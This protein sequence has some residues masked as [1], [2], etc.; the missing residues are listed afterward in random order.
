MPGE[1][2]TGSG[3]PPDPMTGKLI[4]ALCAGRVLD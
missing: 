2:L 3:T 1:A 4:A